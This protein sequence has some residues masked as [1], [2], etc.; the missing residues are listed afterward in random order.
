MPLCSNQTMPPDE[1][2]VWHPPE[3]WG[4]VRCGIDLHASLVLEL[5]TLVSWR[6]QSE[7]A[8]QSLWPTLKITL[9]M[10]VSSTRNIWPGRCIFTKGDSNHA[11]IYVRV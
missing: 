4:D 2:S 11:C 10:I 7:A 5:Q 3:V 1:L 6:A 8:S 9:S